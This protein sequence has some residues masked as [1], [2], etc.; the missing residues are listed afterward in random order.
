MD[1]S[2]IIIGSG[3]GSLICGTVLSQHNFKVTI[4]EMNKQIGGNL[5]TFYRHY[6]L[7][8][9]GVHYIGGLGKNQ[10][11]YKIFKYLKIIDKLNLEKLD[12][13]GFDI[14]KFTNDNN[15]YKL[16]QGYSNF[17]KNLI[18]QFPK[19]E[20]AIQ[21]YI[22]SI[23]KICKQF[24]L[25]NLKY[26]QNYDKEK[27]MSISINDFLDQLT[28]NEKLKNVLLG[29]NLL[30]LAEKDKTPIYVHALII[31]SFI[32]GAYK[33]KN[34]GSKIASLLSSI[35]RKN[36]GCILTK[37]KVTEII[38]KDKY[39][40]KIVLENGKSFSA[41][42]YISG[43]HPA[44]TLDLIS[45]SKI[46]KNSKY[47]I[48]NLEN[49]MSFFTLYVVLKEKTIKYVNSNLYLHFKDDSWVNTNYKEEEWPLVLAVYYNKSKKH[50]EYADSMSILTYMKF[51]DWNKWSD[52]KN[53]TAQP[54]TRGKEY[55]EYKTNMMKKVVNR[56]TNELPQLKSNIIEIHA[57]TP[58][59]YR[60]Y[61]NTKDGSI[62]GISKNYIDSFKT[63]ISSKSKISN[64]FFTGQNINLH[65]ILGVSVSAIQ[66]LSHFLD[67]DYLLKEINK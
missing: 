57:S 22:K 1:K 64:L 39:V 2:V 62:Y 15:Y 51:A 67:I 53:T 34:G 26:N 66:T 31:N 11:L 4:F 63:N 55:E 33:I 40:D 25:Y 32:Q 35:I 17:T 7:F 24:P 13:N 14:V 21:N 8:D 28:A 44:A 49:T 43:I 5:Q 56:L 59:T 20:V 36:N 30:Y 61:M 60:D 52:T 45:N 42:Y 29:N 48:S 47:R 27:Y 12:K 41:D 9:T 3:L 16:G 19:E 18:L 58:L 54:S 46:I 23:K 38:L 65:G 10:N 50:P 37:N 6:N